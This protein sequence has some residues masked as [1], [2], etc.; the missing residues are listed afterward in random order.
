[1][2]VIT[3]HIL[4]YV[5]PMNVHIRITVAVLFILMIN[6]VYV[7][8]LYIYSANLLLTMHTRLKDI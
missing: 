8:M 5:H 2:E 4:N 3:Q 1:M 7:F 6:K